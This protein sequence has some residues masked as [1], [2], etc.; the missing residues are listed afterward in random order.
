M[1]SVNTALGRQ[2]SVSGAF[3]FPGKT[4]R[5]QNQITGQ[6]NAERNDHQVVKVAQDRD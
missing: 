3:R 1:P 2:L 5:E 6:Q 4:Q